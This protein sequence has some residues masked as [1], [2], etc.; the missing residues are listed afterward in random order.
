MRQVV[1]L[2][3]F[4][5]LPFSTMKV[6]GAPHYEVLQLCASA[7]VSTDPQ[8]ALLCR[9]TRQTDAAAFIDDNN[10]RVW[11]P[12]MVT[13]GLTCLAA[14]KGK[15]TAQT[16][17]SAPVNGGAQQNPNYQNMESQLRGSLGG[18]ANFSGSNPCASAVNSGF[19]AFD[20]NKAFRGEDSAYYEDLQ[21][22][23]QFVSNGS[24]AVV[25][26]GGGSTGL[27]GPGGDLPESCQRARSSMATQDRFDCALTTDP[28]MPRFIKDPRFQK[29]FQ[30]LSGVNLDATINQSTS[31]IYAKVAPGVLKKAYDQ[32]KDKMSMSQLF[33]VGASLG[34]L[35]YNGLATND[36][37]NYMVKAFVPSQIRGF[38]PE[39]NLPGNGNGGIAGGHSADASGN[40]TTSSEGGSGIQP[41]IPRKDLALSTQQVGDETMLTGTIPD[42]ESAIRKP[43]SEQNINS[44]PKNNPAFS[45]FARVS[46]RYRLITRAGRFG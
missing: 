2:F 30:Q 32:V 33:S 42:N 15:N 1:T 13:C 9:A 29:E 17:L 5:L 34:K 12:V 40:A 39:P 14:M 4:T 22:L 37:K 6:F 31:Q 23:E 21:A 46:R 7:R 20:A 44:D 8:L 28:N 16:C 36:D 10:S 35:M 19:R 3:L 24:A 43:T 18:K 45:L 38:M 26:Q 25:N 27:S 41:I 11:T